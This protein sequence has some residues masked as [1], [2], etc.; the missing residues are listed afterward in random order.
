LQAASHLVLDVQAEEGREDRCRE[1]ADERLEASVSA[2][3][4]DADGDEEHRAAEDRTKKDSSPLTVALC[5]SS[6]P[7][8]SL[9]LDPQVPTGGNPRHDGQNQD[10]KHEQ[11][12]HKSMLSDLYR[13][14][15]TAA[16]LLS[17][18]EKGIGTVAVA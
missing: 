7:V 8:E 4:V 6:V 11:R 15:K 9:L 17:L 18:R 13:S 14:V 2:G 1:N 5:E 16:V 3:E 12:V 10:A